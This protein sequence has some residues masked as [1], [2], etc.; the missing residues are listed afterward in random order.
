M[1]MSTAQA[2]TKSSLVYVISPANF[3]IRWFFR[4]V[5][6]HLDCAGSR[7]VRVAVSESV[8]ARHFPCKFSREMALVTCSCASVAHVHVRFD[9]TRSHK[10]E[11]SFSGSIWARHFSCKFSRKVALVICLCAFRL[12]RLVQ[13]AGRG[14]GIHLG[15][16]IL[17]QNSR[18]RWPACA[19]RL[20]RQARAKCVRSQHLGRGIFPVNS[21]VRWLL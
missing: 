12:R 9:C 8:W 5:H 4:R 3:R 16:G 15:R 13:S 2:R 6:V 1:C 7:K 10:V 11:V 21:R 19:F 18:I 14:L 20:R 17:S